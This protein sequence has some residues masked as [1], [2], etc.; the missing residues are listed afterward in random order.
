MAHYTENGLKY[1]TEEEVN[2]LSDP[3]NLTTKELN[4]EAAEMFVVRETNFLIDCMIEGKDPI[5]ELNRR[6]GYDNV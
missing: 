3:K 4:E 5:E 1:W 2:F 6:G